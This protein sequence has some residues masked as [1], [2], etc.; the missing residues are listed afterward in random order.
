[1]NND[2]PWTNSNQTTIHTQRLSFLSP[3]PSSLPEER[4]RRNEAMSCVHTQ[5]K[6]TKT[7]EQT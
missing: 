2:W 5:R 6:N 3:S 1:L 4:A 7:K